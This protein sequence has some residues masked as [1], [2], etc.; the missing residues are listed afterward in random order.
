MTKQANPYTNSNNISA[1]RN[2]QGRHNAS[3]IRAR[4]KTV[5]NI[6]NFYHKLSVAHTK[7]TFAYRKYTLPAQT[8]ARSELLPLDAFPARLAGTSIEIS[9]FQ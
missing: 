4:K 7:Q 2:A 1:V 6:P 5:E 9:S 8:H 3:R